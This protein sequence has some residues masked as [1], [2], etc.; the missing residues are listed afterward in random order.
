MAFNSKTAKFSHQLTFEGAWPTS[1]AFLDGNRL[2]AGNRDGELYIWNLGDEPAEPSESEKKD[3]DREAP[4]LH[5]TRKLLG[6]SNGVTRLLSADAGK[7][8]VS[9]SLDHSI[10]LWDVNASASGKADAVLDWQQRRSQIKRDKS[11]EE[12]L[13]TA[14]GLDIETQAPAH[15]M[16]GHEGWVTA[17]SLNQDQSRLVS[18]DDNSQVIVW[19]FAARKEIHRW[20][21]HKLAGVTSTAV[22]PDGK[23]AFV[24]EYGGRRGDFDRPPAQAKI[25]ALDSG[26]MLLDLLVVKFPEVKKRDNSYGYGTKWIKWMGRGFVAADISPDGKILAVGMG[27]ETGDA[28]VYLIDME[29]GKEIRTASKHKGGVCDVKFTADGQHLMTSGRDTVLKVVQVSD[30]KEIA[31]LGKSRGGQFKDWFAAIAISP[32]KNQVAVAD[33]GGLVHVWNGA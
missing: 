17:C 14:P 15:V 9:A 31:T 6:H 3:K 5:P 30:G 22:S 12:E 33:I 2:A 4:N 16:L 29:T 11:N 24:C 18:G 10:C 27:G 19:D 13:L 1:V 21:G 32:D 7:T 20:K 23:K 8:L 25:F 28:S 26:E